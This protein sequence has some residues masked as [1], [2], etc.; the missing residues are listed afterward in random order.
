[1]FFR[2]ALLDPDF[3]PGPES[4]EARLFSE[5]EIPWESLAF[6]TVAQTLKWFFADRRDGQYRLHTATIRYEPKP[7][8]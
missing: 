3:D 1:M 7:H 6:R 2:A 5:A 4:L 8:G